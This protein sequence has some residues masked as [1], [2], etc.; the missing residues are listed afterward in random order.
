MS[1]GA[2]PNQETPTSEEPSPWA[3]ILYFAVAGLVSLG[4][5]FALGWIVDRFTNSAFPWHWGIAIPIVAAAAGVLSTAIKLS[6]KDKDDA[7]MGFLLTLAVPVFG[8]ALF[9]TGLLDAIL[10]NTDVE[11]GPVG[12]YSTTDA[13]LDL[14]PPICEAVA[15]GRSDRFIV[16]TL[17]EL[18]IDGAP[19]WFIEEAATKAIDYHCW[20]RNILR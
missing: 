8:V 19:D 15:E 16:E 13:A 11:I 12:V 6:R 5:W 14:A 4:L 2:A 17:I 18:E 7:V 9:A 10:T 1:D 3:P 20:Y